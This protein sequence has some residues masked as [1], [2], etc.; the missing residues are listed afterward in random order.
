MTVVEGILIIVGVT[1]MIGSFL[2]SEKLS[3]KELDRIAELSAKE[4]KMI[5][6][7]DFAEAKVRVEDLIDT[8]I[9]E[10]SENIERMLDK[11]SNEKIMAI[12]EYSD[13]VIEN[14]DKTYSEVMFLYSMLNDRHTELTELSGKLSAVFTGLQETMK[15]AEE[16]KEELLSL[17]ELVR[18]QMEEETAATVEEAVPDE[19][20][21]EAA[22]EAVNNN[23]RILDLFMQGMSYVDIAKELKLGLGEVKLVIELFKGEE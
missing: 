22:Q 11:E 6:E 10:S 3:T 16:Q 2:V 1:F 17:P 7:R 13:T 5:L 14:M 9:E 19:G 15:K 21:Q 12:G 23:D 18:V 20:T 4:V 8:A